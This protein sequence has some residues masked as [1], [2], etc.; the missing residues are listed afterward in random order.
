[1]G[2]PGN[3]VAALVA[4]LLLGAAVTAKLAGRASKRLRGYPLKVAASL[5]RRPG[6]TEFVPARLIRRPEGERLEIVGGGPARLAPLVA[7]DGLA[8]LSPAQAPVEAG[9]TVAFHPF[10]GEFE[11]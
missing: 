6:R 1:M 8:E 5:D 9:S 11:M 2:H 4:W 10:R 7:A 3:P